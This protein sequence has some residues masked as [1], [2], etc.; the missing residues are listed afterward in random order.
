MLTTVQISQKEIASAGFR[1]LLDSVEPA[2]NGDR[3]TVSSIRTYLVVRSSTS[4]APGRL[5]TH[6]DRRPVEPTGKRTD[7]FENPS[8]L[9]FS[10]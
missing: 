1:A 6:D 9:A 2:P 5:E 7:L 10:R 8:E 3:H 4:M